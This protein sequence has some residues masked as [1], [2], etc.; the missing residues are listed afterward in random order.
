MLVDAED[1]FGN[2]ATTY[3]GPVTIS[4]ANGATGLAGTE[5]VN[6]V[7]GVATFTDLSIGA[8]GTYNLLGSS[9]GLVTTAPDSTPIVIV[10]AAT[11]LYIIQQPPSPVQAGST[12]GFTVGADDSFGN[13]TTIFSGNVSVAIMANPGGSNPAGV[14]ETVPVIDGQ[15]VFSGLTLNKVG[16]NYTLKVTSGSLTPVTTNPI[17]VTN[18]PADH[19]LI[20]QANEPPSSVIAG[21]PFGLT[22]T[23]LDPYGNV[24][25]GFAGQVSVSI[26]GGTLTGTTTLNV[27]NGQAAF[28]GLAIDTTG[29]FKLLAT[30]TPALT[31]TMSTSI[32]VNPATAS[33]LVW[34]A[35]PPTSVVHNFP[36]GAA[37]ALEDQYGNLETGSNESV[38]VALDNN[39]NLASLGGDTTV[40]LVNGVASFINLSITEVGNGYTLQ[41]TAGNLTSAASTGIDVTPT[42]AAAHRNHR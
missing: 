27:A 3:N 37:L 33:Q 36:F 21:Q 5:T 40:N 7:A 6:A 39:P 28:S 20:A 19:L 41:G 31:S 2:I 10:G 18:A 15:A 12:W 32:T 22:V 4:L 17:D 25:V 23:A 14:A 9:P 29:T 24:D 11:Q 1:E 34:A 13:P 16:M 26:A 8:D 42:P 35:E 38:S 30:S